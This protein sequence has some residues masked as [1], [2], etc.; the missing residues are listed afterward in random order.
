MQAS[1]EEVFEALGSTLRSFHVGDYSSAHSGGGGVGGFSSWRLCVI[2]GVS[3]SL[4]IPS[5]TDAPPAAF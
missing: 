2:N 1:T 3:E 4:V 5:W